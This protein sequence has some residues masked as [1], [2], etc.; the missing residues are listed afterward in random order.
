MQ[1]SLSYV[2]IVLSVLVVGLFGG[3]THA[4]TLYGSLYEVGNLESPTTPGNNFESILMYYPGT[5]GFIA[6]TSSADGS[7]DSELWVS[8]VFGTN[9]EIVDPNP[10]DEY[11]C[12]QPGRHGTHIYNDEVYFTAACEDGALIFKLTGQDS[13][14]LEYTHTS[15]VSFPVTAELNGNL[16]FFYN[17]GFIEYD[18]TTYT[19]VTTATN[20]PTGVPFESTSEFNNSL[21]LAFST[22]E[23]DLFDGENF[24]QLNPTQFLGS[25]TGTAVFNDTFYVGNADNTNG[26]T[27]Y[28]Y[29]EDNVA[30]GLDPFEVVL[31]LDPEDAIINKMLVSQSFDGNSYLTIYTSNA[32]NGT[33]VFALNEDDTQ[34]N[35]IDNG[36]GGMNPENNTEVV[37]VIKRVVTDS[38]ETYKVMLFATQNRTAET[39]IHVLALGNDFAFTPLDGH[40]VTGK[41]SKK[42]DVQLSAGSVLKVRVPKSKVNQGDV[43][44]LWVDGKKVF[45]KT[46]AGNGTVTLRY[47][48][49]RKLDSG[50][51]LTLQVGRRMS[52]GQSTT[53]ILARNI[54]MGDELTAQID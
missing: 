23:Y 13:V 46:A 48:A 41:K 10:L 44:S 15:A 6:V 32:L 2:A 19:D 36:L 7:S 40:F 34:I 38:G 43:F 39:K 18:G 33:N 9:W 42:F 50:D 21:G 29:V 53:K 28:K 37:D 8:D 31:Q 47:K 11:N 54:V 26:A 22:G 51:T 17:G 3:A 35:L 5:D 12:R 45:K 30:A 24:T 16:Y 25:L 49:A 52:Y 14:S 4:S 1:R 27:V 20:Q